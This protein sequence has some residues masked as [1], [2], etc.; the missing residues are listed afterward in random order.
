MK[1]S[2]VILELY[3]QAT[4]E[5]QFAAADWLWYAFRAVQRQEDETAIA[6]VA[7]HG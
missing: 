2:N 1:L 3:F 4:N 5:S 6:A 7:Y